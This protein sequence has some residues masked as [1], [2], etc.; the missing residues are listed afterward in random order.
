METFFAGFDDEDQR[1]EIQLNSSMARV[2]FSDLPL[3]RC[4]NASA[5]SMPPASAPSTSA[6][7]F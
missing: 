2:V 7:S 6:S 4:S 5:S 3:N 1:L